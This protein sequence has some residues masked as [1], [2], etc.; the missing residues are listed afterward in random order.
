MSTLQ[1]DE[2]KQRQRMQWDAS[3]PG[4]KKWERQFIHNLQPLT[5]LLVK[6]TGIKPGYSVLDLACGTGEPGLTIAN[7]VGSNGRVVG[8]DLAPGM[9]VVARERMASQGLKDVTSQVNEHDDLPALQDSSFDAAVCRL[10]LMFMP[11]PVRMLKAIRRVLKPGGKA[12]VVVWG[13]PEKA[14]FFSVPMK[15]VM[16]HLPDTKP[17]P[18]G[19]PGGPFGIPSQEMLGGLFTKAGFSN[20]KSQTADV[21]V[22]DAK[23]PEEYWEA[24]TETAGP[25]VLL[26]SKMS[27][28]KKKDVREELVQ[29]LRGMFPSGPVRL[30]GEAIVGTGTKAAI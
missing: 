26:L 28:E 10:G 5:N 14:P 23:S 21:T 4:W 1:S 19:T 2:I 8:V 7:I 15:A 11:D 12:S 25:I 24:S 17:L 18:P 3:A 13:P 16:K 27:P 30:G 20:F 9:L 6:S 22:F 29:T